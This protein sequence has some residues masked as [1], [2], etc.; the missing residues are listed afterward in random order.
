MT[1]ASPENMT[2]IYDMFEYANDVSENIFG[3]G[4]LISLYLVIF[5][6]LKGRG[7]ETADCAAVSGFIT[8][9]AAVLLFLWEMIGGRHLFI[10][11]AVYVLSMLW[12]F[13]NK[14]A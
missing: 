7:D 2:G 6:W 12:A 8:S 14:S 13:F 4:L 9:I 1:Y 10:V 3:A 5:L 11:F